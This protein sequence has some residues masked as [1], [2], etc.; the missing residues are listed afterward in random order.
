MV[1]AQLFISIFLSVMAA[2]KAVAAD[3][4]AMTADSPAATADL[5]LTNGYIYT[6]DQKKTVAEAVAVRDGK[7]VFVGTNKAAGRYFSKGTRRIDLQ[8]QLL[9]PGFIDSHSHP[10]MG[11]ISSKYNLLIQNYWSAADTLTEIRTFV[12]RHPDRPVIEGEGYL[13][14]TFI[15]QTGR[16]PTKEI[17]DEIELKRPVLILDKDGHSAWVNSAALKLAGIDHTTPDPVNGKIER[18]PGTP[19]YGEPTGQLFEDA[20]VMVIK[21]LPIIDQVAIMNAFD[22]TQAFFSKNGLTTLRD[23]GVAF[24]NRRQFNRMAAMNRLAAADRLNVR[25]LASWVVA[26]RKK[27]LRQQIDAFAAANKKFTH[28]NFKANGLKFLIDGTIEEKSAFLLQPYCSKLVVKRKN[29]KGKKYGLDIWGK[30]GA[31]LAE[32]FRLGTEHGFQIN[33]HTVGDA[34][35]KKTLDALETAEVPPVMRP[36]LEHVQLVQKTDIDRMARLQVSANV[37]PSWMALDDYFSLYFYPVLGFERAYNDTYPYRSLMQ[38]GVNV[39]AGSD[40]IVS[41]PDI[42]FYFFT[43]MT[44]LYPRRIYDQWYEGSKMHPYYSDIDRPLTP[45]LFDPVGRTRLPIGSLRPVFE[46]ATSIESIIE[47]V[48]INGATANKID[49]LTGSIEP[50]K[51][52]D[53]VVLDRNV[54]TLARKFMRTGKSADLEPVANAQVQMTFF[55]GRLVYRALLSALSPPSSSL[56]K[57]IKR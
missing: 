45:D 47:S 10:V 42:P 53:M 29:C 51:F 57:Q 30:A 34:A 25:L 13:R 54:I 23:M 8:G 9:L 18:V 44:R 5:V 49:H 22:H 12:A 33:A 40:W 17:L 21:K 16:A 26:P 4:P 39:T 19:G 35:V 55:E 15:S 7:I 36:S 56:Q 46:R 38:A 24:T 6:V 32:A 41:N 1:L 52:A 27:E 50:G 37:T 3:S 43:G 2:D 14:S 11:A 48:T 20:F 28:R 31:D